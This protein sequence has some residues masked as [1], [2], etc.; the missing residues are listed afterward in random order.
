MKNEG[1][2]TLSDM[3]GGSG[4]NQTKPKTSPVIYHTMGRLAILFGII[5]GLVVFLTILDSGQSPLFGFGSRQGLDAKQT[6]VGF[7]VCLGISLLFVIPG[8]ICI[9]VGK[10]IELIQQG[11]LSDTAN[12]SS[13][14][15]N[16]LD[17]SPEE[18]EHHPEV[19]EVA[20][21]SI[22][23]QHLVALGEIDDEAD[24]TS[25]KAGDKDKES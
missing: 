5:A 21:D 12:L 7:G 23:F 2:T 20:D 9:G 15:T 22:P 10:M 18:N 25:E 11:T 24:E 6:F 1:Y 16:D 4:D 13:K 8:V 17:D 3:T 19:E 14:P